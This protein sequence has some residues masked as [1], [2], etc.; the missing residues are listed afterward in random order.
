MH[1]LNYFYTKTLKFDLIHKFYYTELKKI[2]NLKQI[3]LNFSCKATELKTL[4]IH[5][6]ALELISN[7]KGVV[8]ISKHPNLLLKIRKGNPTG[9]KITLRKARMIN[10]L[11]KVYTDIVS[12]S[13][14]F[15][16]LTIHQKVTKNAFSFSVK[17]TLTF[18]E[19]GE[20][21]YLFNKLT[22][23]NISFVANVNTKK[24]ML[25]LLTSLQLPL[26]L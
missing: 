24:E 5:L 4:A 9:C 6:L 23:L 15:S 2:P 26:K 25:F 1:F 17:N 22:N 8:T 20:H 7:Q 11:S 10:F 3:I 19:I 21:Y 14:N 16:G 12:K 13:K 18:T